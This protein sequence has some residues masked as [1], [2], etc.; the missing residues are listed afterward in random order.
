MS[1]PNFIVTFADGTV[2]KMDVP[3]PWPAMELFE[4]RMCEPADPEF[5]ARF[6]KVIAAQRKEL[7]NANRPT[8]RKIGR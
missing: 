6:H 2:T 3:D 4:K 8:R 7:E 1:T 5:T